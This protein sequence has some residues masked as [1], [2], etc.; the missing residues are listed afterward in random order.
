MNGRFDNCW[1]H[2]RAASKADNAIFGAFN[3]GR[4]LAFHR[5][6]AGET[7]ATASEMPPKT[8]IVWSWKANVPC[9]VQTFRSRI[10]VLQVAPGSQSTKA[11]SMA[12]G[13]VQQF[14]TGRRRFTRLFARITEEDGSY[15]VQVRLHNDAMPA[16]EDTAWGEEIA[17]SIEFASEMITGLAA[18]FSIPQHRITLVIRMDN[19]G[20]NTRH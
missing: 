2:G 19:V 8:V 12:I 17:D 1:Y 9:F 6:W 18:R 13:Q 11:R 10:K 15:V 5:E 16:P 7:L 3:S 4:L 14:A 20:E